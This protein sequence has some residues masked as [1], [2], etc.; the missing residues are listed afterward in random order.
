[1]LTPATTPGGGC[2]ECNDHFGASIPLTAQWQP[3]QI[4]FADLEPLGFG[5]PRP[6]SVDLTQILAL[7]LLFAR[8]VTFDVWFD[9]IEL[10]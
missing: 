1:M 6:T 7:E 2:T 3:V 8:N 5:S 4:A 10:Y 9:D